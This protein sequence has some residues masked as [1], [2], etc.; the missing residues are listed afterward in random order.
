MAGAFVGQAKLA[1][2]AVERVDVSGVARGE[3][4]SGHGYRETFANSD[5]PAFSSRV[6]CCLKSATPGS[7]ETQKL[8]ESPGPES[9]DEVDA[10]S[11]SVCLSS[12]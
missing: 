9:A 12:C 10:W 1:V 4:L 7:D 3:F 2:L 5:I 6:T 8:P 11:R